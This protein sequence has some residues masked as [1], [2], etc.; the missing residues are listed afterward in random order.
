MIDELLK[1]I[2]GYEVE[3]LLGKGGMGAVVLAK[4]SAD[5]LAVAIKLALTDQEN[6]SQLIGRAKREMNTAKNFAHP[7]L[8][9]I[10]DGGVVGDNYIYI[11]MER[12]VGMDLEETILKGKVPVQRA[13]KSLIH[14]S[15]ALSYIHARDLLHRDI[16]P[17]NIFLHES[18]RTIL[19]DFGLVLDP[20]STRMTDTNNIVGTLNFMSPEQLRR[21]PLTARSD[22][23][24]LGLTF[25]YALSGVMPYNQEHALRLAVGVRLPKIKE[26]CLVE[27][28]VP[29]ELSKV[30]MRCLE[31]KPK[32]RFKSADDLKAALTV[33]LNGEFRSPKVYELKS[34][35]GKASKNTSKNHIVPF[36]FLSLLIFAL[37]AFKVFH[38]WEK[39]GERVTTV[40]SK[41]RVLAELSRLSSGS[42][43]PSRMEFQN[44][45]PLLSR[46][47]LTKKVEAKDNRYPEL[48]AL[49]FLADTL[50]KQKSYDKHLDCLL[51]ALRW[52]GPFE[53]YDGALIIDQVF[54]SAISYDRSE[55][56]IE[57]LDELVS[58]ASSIRVK[59]SLLFWIARLQTKHYSKI[60]APNE[61]FEDVETLLKTFYSEEGP[62][63]EKP[64]VIRALFENYLF[65]EKEDTAL[66]VLDFI[67]EVEKGHM[68]CS[69]QQR[70]GLIALA[71]VLVRK[72]GSGVHQRGEREFLLEARRLANRALSM[73]RSKSLDYKVY[74]RIML[75]NFFIGEG[76][77][78][79][80]VEV[81]DFVDPVKLDVRDRY[82]YHR[83][84]AEVFR[85]MGKNKE[86]INELKLAR[87]NA[88]NKRHG[89][90]VMSRLKLVEQ[91]EEVMRK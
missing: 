61:L 34:K 89:R 16:K 31:L 24:S 85:L 88:F 69:S 42:W 65:I 63:I 90:K 45:A 78:G 53:I 59:R 9:K 56:A 66:K 62:V 36:L 13:T 67:K 73:H 5:G 51:L 54:R 91:F 12:L 8:P 71:A 26:L 35:S 33:C 52:C 58:T 4:R 47:G 6:T 25:Y 41:G 80:A 23:Y 60:N 76:I 20:Y 1:S 79:K 18:G 81:I 64:V 14:M 87:N 68:I 50:E 75:A 37:L 55:M 44:L 7:Y 17:S 72:Q 77:P 74:D 30:V 27:P 22:I 86:A 84:R 57:K 2:P 32:N 49:F 83:C 40:Y 21:E 48:E 10:I 28:S 46:V 70:F 3:S 82:H 39:D 11:V 15:E 38:P 43:P 19:L 29:K